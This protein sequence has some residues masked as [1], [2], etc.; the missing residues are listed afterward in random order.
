MSIVNVCVFFL[1]FFQSS[2]FLVVEVPSSLSK[3]TYD[4]KTWARFQQVVGKQIGPESA[5]LDMAPIEASDLRPLL[6]DTLSETGDR[7]IVSADDLEGR[8]FAVVDGN[9]RLTA[10][11]SPE[12]VDASLQPTSVRCAIVRFQAVEE[13]VEAGTLLNYVRA[14]QATDNFQDRCVWVRVH[15]KIY[16]QDCLVPAQEKWDEE[17]PE[18]SKKT[19]RS[20]PKFEV[21]SFYDWAKTRTGPFRLGPEKFKP[22]ASSSVLIKVALNHHPVV[23]EYIASKFAGTKKDAEAAEKA[24]TR[25]ALGTGSLWNKAM[26]PASTQLWWVKSLFTVA[27]DEK[28]KILFKGG[29]NAKDFQSACKRSIAQQALLVA[30]LKQLKAEYPVEVT[31]VAFPSPSDRKLKKLCEQLLAHKWWDAMARQKKNTLIPSLSKYV[32]DVKAALV[33]E[34]KKQELARQAQERLEA[35]AKQKAEDQAQLAKEQKSEECLEEIRKMMDVCATVLAIDEQLA[36][37][38]LD[39]GPTRELEQK[40]A[41]LM[42][43]VDTY[44][45]WMANM[46]D[47]ITAEDKECED[48]T[49]FW[50]LLRAVL[51]DFDAPGGWGEYFFFFG[52][53]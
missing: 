6:Q 16:M 50:L 53:C 37:G 15:K 8:F 27:S 30:T 52:F 46:A 2:E 41:G 22:Y 10:L 4:E 36:E 28:S 13:L 20:R 49:E 39:R 11:R 17:H 21:K 33:A 35:L 1:F 47:S 24:F 12:V 18:A 3:G 7:V 45:Q 40:K 43:L 48:V 38:G 51:G 9:H 29:K 5:A 44:L 34:Q 23:M 26:V 19:K 25:A 32:L 42:A 14:I 31:D